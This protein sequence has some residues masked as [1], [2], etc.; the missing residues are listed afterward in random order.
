[1]TRGALAGGLLLMAACG[2]VEEAP[3]AEQVQ[4]S[5]AALESCRTDARQFAYCVNEMNLVGLATCQANEYR[6]SYSLL[7][8][9][10]ANTYHTITWTCCT[11]Q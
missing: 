1:M 8:Q 3:A 6:Q 11:Q 10:S 2:G 4:P 5:E 9:C 7:G